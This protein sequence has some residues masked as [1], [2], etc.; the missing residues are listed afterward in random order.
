MRQTGLSL[1][2]LLYVAK[3]CDWVR[4]IT[5]L[6][7]LTRATLLLQWKLTAKAELN[8]EI[9]KSYKKK[10]NKSSQ[11]SWSEQPCEPKRL[12]VALNNAGVEKKKLG[13]LAI[14]VNLEGLR[15]EFWKER[16]VSYGG[17]LCPQIRHLLAAIKLVVSCSELYFA[18]CCTLKRTGKQGKQG[19]VESAQTTTPF[20]EPTNGAPSAQQ[21]TDPA[22][23]PLI[24]TH[25]NNKEI[26]TTGKDIITTSWRASTAK[27]TKTPLA[28][29]NVL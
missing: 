19:S 7:N 8:C 27:L 14:A 17:N 29:G 12:N 13:K 16:R 9:C 20:A 24:G 18:R 25:L 3:D 2:F 22:C 4:N 5:P 10:M 11:F 26:S 1:N 6:S 21:K 23:L 28:M 15:F